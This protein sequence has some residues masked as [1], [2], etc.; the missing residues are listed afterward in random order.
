MANALLNSGRS[1]FFSLCEWWVISVVAKKCRHTL[2]HIDSSDYFVLCCLNYRGVEDPATWA[3]SIGNS[4]R[5]TGDISDN[6]DRWTNKAPHY[7]RL[8]RVD[9]H[10]AS[11]N[12]G[13]RLA[14]ASSMFWKTSVA[15]HGHV[16]VVWHQPVTNQKII[17]LIKQAVILIL[18]CLVY[19]INPISYFSQL[20]AVG[21]CFKVVHMVRRH[22]DAAW[23]SEPIHK[24]D[25]LACVELERLI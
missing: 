15:R 21:Q 20:E 6:W 11:R 16:L 4:W 22:K 25:G 14:D 17:K 24:H 19:Y 8:D 7:A 18:L 3:K 10:F 13:H 2:M 12:L 23:Q 1:I 9:P 5:T